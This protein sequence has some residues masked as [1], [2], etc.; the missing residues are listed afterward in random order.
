MQIRL[1]TRVEVDGA[2]F[3]FGV[4]DD[5]LL[6]AVN[7]L[8]VAAPLIAME[9]LGLDLEAFGEMTDEE[10]LALSE[11]KDFEPKHLPGEVKQAFCRLFVAGVQDWKGVM[12]EDGEPWKFAPDRLEGFPTDEKV[13]VV[14]EYMIE[15]KRTSKK[16]SGPGEQDT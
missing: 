8:A 3:W 5:A 4:A 9:V 13:A 12:G 10:A 11:G 2:Q 7:M 1:K 14:C 15:R 16:E 6:E